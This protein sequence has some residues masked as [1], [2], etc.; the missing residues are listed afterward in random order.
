MRKFLIPLIASAA[1]IAPSTALA[2]GWGN[3]DNDTPAPVTLPTTVTNETQANT[4][5]NAYVIKNAGTIAGIDTSS[6]WNSV[7]RITVS[8]VAT[9]CLQHPVVAARFGCIVRFN[10][11]VRDNDRRGRNDYRF[12]FRAH[13]SSGRGGDDDWGRRDRS[14]DRVRSFGCLAALRIVAGPGVTPATTVAF[15]DCTERPR[16]T[17]Y[18]S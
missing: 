3:D 15:A 9:A 11:A 10:L 13:S 16:A 14:R 2:G 17:P 6:R 8:D 7:R 12:H 5:A 18:G 4:Y 1:L